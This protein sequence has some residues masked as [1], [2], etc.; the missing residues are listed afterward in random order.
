MSRKIENLLPDVQALQ[1]KG[2]N[3]AE[4]SRKLK[5]SYA[6]VW[7]TINPHKR[8]IHGKSMNLQSRVIKLKYHGDELDKRWKEINLKNLKLKG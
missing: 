4:V 7:Y 1:E 3:I 8:R 2:L 5:V 6:T